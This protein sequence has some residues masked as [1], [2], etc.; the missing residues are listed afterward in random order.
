MRYTT[1]AFVE[2]KDPRLDT[3]CRTFPSMERSAY[4]LL[5]EGVKASAV[6]ALIR[7]RYGVKNARWCQSAINQA[8]A[9]M[10]S[11]REGIGF[12]V[13]LCEEKI[14]NTKKKMKNLNNPVKIAGCRAK[15]RKLETRRDELEQQLA[16]SSF[17]RAVFG[18]KKLLHQLSVASGGRRDELLRKWREK[19]SN[20]F[21]SVGQANQRGNGNTRLAHDESGDDKVYLEVRNWLDAD[22]RLKLHVP[23]PYKRVV[24]E[25]VST[26]ES[27]KLGSRGELVRESKG[28]PYSVRVTKSAKGY[29]V[30]VSFELET[31]RVAWTGRVAG[32]DI[33]PEGIACTIVSRDGNLIVTRFLRDN[34]LISASK[35]K[36]KWVLE[37]L[38]NRML[39]WAR[40]THGCVM[41]ALE[42][43][44]FE[45]A[46]DYS[47]ATNFKLSN[48]MKRK[49]LER[50]KLSALKMNVMTVEVNPAYTSMAATAKYS[51]QFGGF[52]RHQLAAFVIA[53]RA[54]GLGEAPAIECLPKTRREK[55]M[56]NHCMRYYGYSPA[57]QT[58][59]RHEPMEWRNDGDV[60]GRGRMTRLLIA[61]PA[62]TSS[63][64]GSSHTSSGEGVIVAEI[65]IGRTGRVRPNGHTSRG[66]GARGCRVNPPDTAGC[67]SAVIFGAGEDNV[68]R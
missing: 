13:E 15:I 48:F 6:K 25:A 41:I 64:M 1:R 68:I 38:V 8:R 26:A 44:K 21:F 11:Q 37:N 28:L 29:Q 10:A 58:L 16:D 40:D 42:S 24:S 55:A 27:V 50:I 35:N 39:R 23:E 54:L 66:D 67:Q 53:R 34:R 46:Y 52:N 36:R 62:V 51:R 9:V 45:V 49:M 33:N 19:R 31:P 47:P 14:R 20:H 17:P 3:I 18:S 12:R 2:G 57:I 22:F 56:W 4:N 32:I 65:V 59:T 7:E 61:P 5:R 60:N 43:L 63:Q 30:L